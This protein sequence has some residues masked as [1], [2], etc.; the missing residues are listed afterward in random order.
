MHKGIKFSKPR[1]IFMELWTNLNSMKIIQRA[2]LAAA[3]ISF[4]ILGLSAVA[5]TVET[6]AVALNLF[7]LAF[8]APMAIGGAYILL[9]W[10]IT[11]N[12][13]VS[14]QAPSQSKPHVESRT[15]H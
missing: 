2:A 4:A 7:A 12:I 13:S 15:A 6:G 5:Y 8:A 11:G 10:I 1:L 14:S 9:N 3:A